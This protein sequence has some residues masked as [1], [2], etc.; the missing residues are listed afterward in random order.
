MQ[1]VSQKLPCILDRIFFEIVTETEVTQHFEE[2]VVTCGETD[3]F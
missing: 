2:S 1:N 3:V